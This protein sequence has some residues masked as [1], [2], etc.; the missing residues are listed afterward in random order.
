MSFCFNFIFQAGDRKTSRQCK[1]TA[2]T[3]IVNLDEINLDELAREDPDESSQ[4]SSSSKKKV[5]PKKRTGPRI[6][7]TKDKKEKKKA[8]ALAAAAAA[9]AGKRGGNKKGRQLGFYFITTACKL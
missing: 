4:D 1:K 2:R 8:K 6:K 7:N 3:G 5:V 9:Q